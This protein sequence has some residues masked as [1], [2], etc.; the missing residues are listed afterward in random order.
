MSN[1]GDGGGAIN[2]Q[3]IQE[4][5]KNTISN[6]IYPKI[7]TLKYIF[8]IFFVQFILY[9]VYSYICIYHLHK[10][11]FIYCS[12]YTQTRVKHVLR[13]LAVTVDLSRCLFTIMQV[14]ATTP[15]RQSNS[16][17]QFNSTRRFNSHQGSLV[18]RA[19]WR[20][21]SSP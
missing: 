3:N 1:A 4:E 19:A 16:N 6:N 2:P 15:L 18:R 17:W 9:C 21:R 20:R 13:P 14:S 11:V 12:F 10:L 5:G 8:D 7:Y